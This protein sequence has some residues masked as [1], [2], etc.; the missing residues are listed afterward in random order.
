MMHFYKGGLHAGGGTGT[1]EVDRWGKDGRAG[2]LVHR[3]GRDVIVIQRRLAGFSECKSTQLVA[4][5][6]NPMW[7]FMHMCRWSSSDPLTCAGICTYTRGGTRWMVRV[8]KSLEIW[9]CVRNRYDTTL[10]LPVAVGSAC[11]LHVGWGA[12]CC[13]VV[14]TGRVDSIYFSSTRATIQNQSTAYILKV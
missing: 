8:V 6:Y 10:G 5:R 13:I 9:L 12:P 14:E 4:S 3:R 11:Q 7:W 1:C 2:I